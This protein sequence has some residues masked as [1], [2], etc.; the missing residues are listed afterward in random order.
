VVVTDTERRQRADAA[1]NAER[2]LRTARAVFA[3]L[4]PEAPLEEI[5]RRA[6]VRIRT[7][8]NHF[9]SK[10]DLVRAALDQVI[11]EDL[12][13][14]AERALADDDPLHGL[15]SLIEAAMAV[16]ARELH[17]VAAAR[18]ARALSAELYTPFYESLTRLAQ[19]A[20]DAGLLRADPSLTTYRGSWPC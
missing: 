4:G 16:V 10:A 12:T 17:T 15:V 18:D 7:L 2:I 6:D 11:A 8:Y 19:R 1:R 20:Q 13:P 3:D 14:A 5:A 9:P